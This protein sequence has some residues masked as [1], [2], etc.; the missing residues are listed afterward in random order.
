DFELSAETSI[1]GTG[2]VQA[3]AG[4]S[5]AKGSDSGLVVGKNATTSI[6]SQAMNEN[7]IDHEGDVIYL[8]LNPKVGMAVQGDRLKWTVTPAGDVMDIQ[9]VYVKWLKH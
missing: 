9:Y 4:Y 6:S 8:W 5:L 3:S 1:L 2:A 7:G